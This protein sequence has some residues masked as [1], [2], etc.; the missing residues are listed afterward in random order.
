MSK[1]K[2]GKKQRISKVQ[3]F[4]ND[5]WTRVEIFLRAY[6]RLPETMDD[7]IT[8]ETLDLFCEKYERGE[9]KTVTTDLG[10]IYKAIK[11]NEVTIY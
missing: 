6:G 8:K 3:N 7:K 4:P 11:S 5:N 10:A 2:E 1:T 9:I